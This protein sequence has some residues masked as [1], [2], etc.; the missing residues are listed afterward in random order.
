MPTPVAQNFSNHA[1]LDPPFHFVALPG[2]LVLLVLSIMNLIR[3]GFTIP[4]VWLLI[5]S[6]LFIL[7]AFKARSYALK[8][9]DRVIRLE[10][11]RRLERLLPAAQQPDIP[12][13]TE[14]QLI[15]L[16]FASD[17]EIPSLTASAVS[18]N[19]TPKAIKQAITSWRA[20]HFRI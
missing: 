8:A 19:L 9:Q 11:R 15:A 2:T 1:R 18:Q 6:I 20:D 10:E 17:S 14:G 3:Q 13:L 5:A 12:K 4:A 7:L 16:R